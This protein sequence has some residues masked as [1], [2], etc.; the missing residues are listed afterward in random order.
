MPDGDECCEEREWWGFRKLRGSGK[1]SGIK[2]PWEEAAKNEPGVFEQQPEPWWLELSGLGEG[3]GRG[4]GREAKGVGR[5]EPL[6][7]F[8]RIRIWE[9][10]EGPDGREFEW[11]PVFWDLAFPGVPGARDRG[12]PMETAS[13]PAGPG[14]PQPQ[15]Q[16]YTC[17]LLW[18]KGKLF[19]WLQDSD[20]FLWPVSK[21]NRNILK[22]VALG[23]MLSLCICG[24][25]ITSHYLA[26]RYKVNTPMLQSFINYCLLFLIYTVMLAF[27][28]VIIFLYILKK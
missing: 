19:P 14:G 22:T 21:E 15:A 25:A 2:R 13:P 18:I 4:W 23:Q 26:E 24:V 12:A 28:S 16:G 17:L 5:E 1:H 11:T 3:S 8:I 9:E 10:L 27:Q 6:Q 20:L 7:D